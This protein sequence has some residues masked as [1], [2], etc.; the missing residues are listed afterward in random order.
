MKKLRLV[1]GKISEKV[2]LQE[3][4][5]YQKEFEIVKQVLLFW[6]DRVNDKQKLIHHLTA[7]NHYKQTLVSKSFITLKKLLSCSRGAKMFSKVIIS[8][9]LNPAF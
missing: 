1:L 3:R 2:E 8:S 9:V 5:R 4:L 7:L 6:R